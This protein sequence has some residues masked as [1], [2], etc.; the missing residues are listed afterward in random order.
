MGGTI[1]DST[2]T[3]KYKAF[4]TGRSYQQEEYPTLDSIKFHI[5]HKYYQTNTTTVIEKTKPQKQSKWHISPQATFGYDPINKQWGFIVGVGV[6]Y[7]F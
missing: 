4:I 7:N 2:D 3:V 5:S 6:N 1:T